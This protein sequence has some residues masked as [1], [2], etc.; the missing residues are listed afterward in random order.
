MAGVQ[1]EDI[2]KVQAGWFREWQRYL[3]RTYCG[4][5]TTGLEVGCGS[6]M[7]M[8]NLSDILE[9]KGIDLDPAEVGNAR[10]RGMDVIEG[11]GGK[12]P[13]AD[14]SFDL[15]YSSFLFIWDPDMARVINEM[16]RV[17][18][19][20][21]C[22]LG[23]PVWNR[24]IVHPSDLSSLVQYER[25]I[26]MEEGGNPEAGMDLLDLISGMGLKHRFGLIP[27]DTSPEEMRRWVSLE[28]EYT[29]KHGRV[30]DDL[31]PT[32]FYIPMVWSVIDISR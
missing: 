5:C 15:V 11:D 26:L 21:V 14:G 13:F 29:V 2:Q 19:R 4:D 22:I 16:I 9:V 30:L 28:R 25:D 27:L 17:A 20:N 18:R 10:K 32:L 24:A 23:E 31:P 8:E 1:P 12:L 3:I 7:V 6:G